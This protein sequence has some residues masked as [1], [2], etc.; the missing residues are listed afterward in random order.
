MDGKGIQFRGGHKHLKKYYH[1]R[2]WK[3]GKFY[4]ISSNNLELITVI[5]CIS[6]SGLFVP[7]SFILLSRP[8]FSFPN[9]SGKIGAITTSLNGWTNNEIGTAWFIETFIPFSNNHKVTDAPILLL[10][11]GHNL[12]K[13]DAFRKAAFK[14]NIIIITFPSKCIH[15]L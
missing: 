6:P 11:D 2:S 12:H 1:L 10:L 3:K 14:H 5:E 7:P 13:L 4:H 9:L 8:T 15:K